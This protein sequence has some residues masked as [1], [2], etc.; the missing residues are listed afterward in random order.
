MIINKFYMYKKG[1]VTWCLTLKIK[2]KH[3]VI[4]DFLISSCK[5]DRNSILVSILTFSRSAISKM[6]IK[7]RDLN[8]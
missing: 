5:H 6:L 2:V 7:S 4:R 1:H 3:R 8:G